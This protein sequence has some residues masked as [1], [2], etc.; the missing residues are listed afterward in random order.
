MSVELYI[1]PQFYNS[2][3]APSTIIPSEWCPDGLSFL[4][5][6]APNLNSNSDSNPLGFAVLNQPP[7]TYNTWYMMK[8]S[9]GAYGVGSYPTLNGWGTNFFLTFNANGSSGIYMK[10]SGLTVGV[11]YDFNLVLDTLVFNAQSTFKIF[12]YNSQGT[13]NSFV[14]SNQFAY[15]INT[16]FI[17]NDTEQIIGIQYHSIGA[18]NNGLL[19]EVS[20][21]ETVVPPPVAADYVSDGQVILDLY[22]DE[23]IPLVLSVD[24]FTNAAEKVQ[25]YSKT[26]SLP[27]TKRNNLILKNEFEITST[28][29]SYYNTSYD[30]N[31]LRKTEI[32]LRQDGYIIFEGFL[33]LDSVKSD[34]GQITY[35]V[36]LFSKVIAL[37]DRLKGLKLSDLDFSELQHE[38]KKS[39][40]KS[41]WYSSGLN[42]SNPL[43]LNS[44]AGN[45]G[46]LNTT[47]LKYPM[48]DWGH[49]LTNAAGLGDPSANL[50][51]PEAT[52]LQQLFRPFIRLKYILQNILR[53]AQFTYTSAFIDSADFSNQFMDFNW[54]NDNS[55]ILE[56]IGSATSHFYGSTS[57]NPQPVN[58]FATTTWGSLR[59]MQYNYNAYVSNLPADYNAS[60][61]V[62]TSTKP[63]QQV[64]VSFAFR[65]L[66]LPTIYGDLNMNYRWVKNEGLA[67]EEVQDYRPTE[68]IGSNL[69][70]DY[71]GSVSFLLQTGDTLA[72]QFQLDQFVGT[73][74]QSN[75][76]PNNNSANSTVVWSLSLS[77]VVSGS[78]LNTLR[79]EMGQWEFLSV[80]LK[81][82]NLITM[83]NPQN[84][85]NII[86]QPY[87]DY[88]PS[89]GSGGGSVSSESR[90]I[91]LDWTNKVDAKT[92][93]SKALVNNKR[94]TLWKYTE[95]ENDYVFKFYKDQFFGFLYGSN[96]ENEDQY[97]ILE[98]QEVIEAKGVAAT[99]I[100]SYDDLWPQLVFPAIY[101]VNDD[102]TTS[103]FDNKPRILYDNGQYAMFANDGN[104][105]FIPS[106][107]GDFGENLQILYRMTTFSSYPPTNSSNDLNF[108]TCQ[109]LNTNNN[110][111]NT[112]CNRFW[113]Q[114]YDELY[115][116]DTRKVSLKID[117]NAADISLFTFNQIVMIKNRAYRVNKIEYKP[118][119]LAKVELI[120]IP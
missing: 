83:P 35:S 30:F 53:D 103:A 32:T 106:Q 67:S 73:I 98:G 87:S 6:G 111:I 76:N 114:Y 84:P 105:V 99:L 44:F 54:G 59:L 80:I 61:G 95:D 92:M 119:T 27:G 90:G 52:S 43:P 102:L 115:N 91:S 112:L 96:T 97:N 48:V 50:G 10:L 65:I 9:G 38:Y 20:V 107:N 41:T 31:P 46:A 63:N 1:F 85:N 116:S 66:N 58:N 68:F 62:F 81:M 78:L 5:I 22:E 100:K 42:L 40:I 64:S 75:G 28:T 93:I 12:T 86:I 39:T 110:T 34:N 72:P 11:S 8:T 118:N 79:G 29:N 45:V 74:E 25:S 17:C 120:L 49:Q 36:N 104:T 60:T 18:T 109:V 16:T 55:P 14:S 33:K 70:Y 56:G 108:G 69:F 117:L 88:F 51:Y 23:D 2:N 24:D 94:T 26:F 82:N 57:I 77:P 113:S 19:T 71:N 47:V 21:M 4:T 13:Q 3:F 37:A 89:I 7:N 101:K 15:N